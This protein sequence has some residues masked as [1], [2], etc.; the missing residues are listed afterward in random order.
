[1]WYQHVCIIYTGF[2]SYGIRVYNELVFP[3]NFKIVESLRSK[4]KHERKKLTKV[5]YMTYANKDHIGLDML[6]SSAEWSNIV[7]EVSGSV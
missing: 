1:M 7:I 5:I 3:A 6:R 4:W 2:V